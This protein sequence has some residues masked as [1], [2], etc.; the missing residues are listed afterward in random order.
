LL[1]KNQK[2]STKN[3]WSFF[4]Y[5]FFGENGQLLRRHTWSR[6][7]FLWLPKK[8]KSQQNQTK[9]YSTKNHS[10]WL[11][12]PL[13]S[14]LFW[15]DSTAIFLTSTQKKSLKTKCFKASTAY[16]INLRIEFHL[17]DVYSIELSLPSSI[18]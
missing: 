1:L 8:H 11:A 7:A 12:I 14:S 17:F 15:M 10:T 3:T 4:Y 13:P 16:K 5:F 18:S 6:C 9:N 2:S